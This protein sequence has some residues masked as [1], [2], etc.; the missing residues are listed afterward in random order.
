[1][2][3]IHLIDQRTIQNPCPREWIC[4]Q[5]GRHCYRDQQALT[6]SNLRFLGSQCSIVSIAEEFATM[7]K[8]KG[9]LHSTNEKFWKQ[10]YACGAEPFYWK[11]GEGKEIIWAMI[12]KSL[13]RQ[14]IFLHCAME[15]NL[16]HALDEECVHMATGSFWNARN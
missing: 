13:I 7:M 14:K 16:V 15:H 3:L 9:I 10:L 11:Q 4:Q 2:D 12:E 6:T 8:N 5:I 1:M